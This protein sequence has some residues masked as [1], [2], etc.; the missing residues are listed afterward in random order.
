MMDR[1]LTLPKG[2]VAWKVLGSAEFDRASGYDP[3][4]RS[5]FSPAVWEQGVTDTFTLV[6]S[7]FPTDARFSLG[8]W[9]PWDWALEAFLMGR[10]F[11]KY[12]YFVWKPGLSLVGRIP[13]ERLAFQVDLSFDPEL[14]HATTASLVFFAGVTP[15]IWWQIHSQVALSFFITLGVEQGSARARFLSDYQLLSDSALA[16]RAPLGTALRWRFLPVWEIEAR[17]RWFSLGYSSGYQS[18]ELL[19]GVVHYW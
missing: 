7:P 10:D 19:A 17:Y 14:G 11:S 16:L 15:T 13:W 8:K 3:V 4:S 1:P 2:L 12:K 9:G 6:W 5:F 18:H